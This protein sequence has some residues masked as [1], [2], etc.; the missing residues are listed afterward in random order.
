MALVDR[1][2]AS[3]HPRR[4]DIALLPCVNLAALD[5]AKIINAL[6]RLNQS[7]G[8]NAINTVLRLTACHEMLIKVIARRRDEG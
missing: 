2:T 1:P 8:A 6:G 5:D 4:A 3:A 7:K